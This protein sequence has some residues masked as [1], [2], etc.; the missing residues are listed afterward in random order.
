MYASEGNQEWRSVNTNKKEAT[1]S[2]R[3]NCLNQLREQ[4]LQSFCIEILK[5]GTSGTDAPRFCDLSKSSW[6]FGRLA[7]CY[8]ATPRGDNATYFVTSPPLKP[9][10][11]NGWRKKKRKEKHK[12][13][14]CS[15]SSVNGNV[16]QPVKISR[17]WVWP[18]RKRVWCPSLGFVTQADGFR[19]KKIKQK[20][21]KNGDRNRRKRAEA[22]SAESLFS[23]LAGL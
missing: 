10:G 11:G 8:S 6:P 3:G 4:R 9:H 13:S 7:S 18:G 21:V 1:I 20:E 16:Q 2:S 14:Y 12:L 17:L 22:H 5:L 23:R 15:N 19:L